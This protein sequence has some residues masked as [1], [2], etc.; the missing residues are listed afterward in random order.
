MI[1]VHPP[2]DMSNR[3]LHTEPYHLHHK[4]TVTSHGTNTISTHGPVAI[5]TEFLPLQSGVIFPLVWV[6]KHACSQPAAPRTLAVFPNAS[7]KV[8]QPCARRLTHEI[9]PRPLFWTDFHLHASTIQPVAP[10][11]SVK[12]R[13]PGLEPT[14]R[15]TKKQRLFRQCLRALPAQQSRYH[16]FLQPPCCNPRRRNTLRSSFRRVAS[17]SLR[18]AEHSDSVTMAFSQTPSC[19]S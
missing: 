12:A 8:A 9:A 7:S 5:T 2:T 13:P 3:V 19:F 17:I 1:M 14:R 16:V 6:V 15:L 18:L 4:H 11:S 10:A